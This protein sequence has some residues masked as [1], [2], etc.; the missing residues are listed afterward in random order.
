MLMH[1]LFFIFDQKYYKQCDSVAKLSFGAPLVNVF[2]CHFENIWLE[3]FL[4]QFKPVVYWR[5]VDHT[6]LFF[7]STEHVENFK[8]YLNN[9]HKSISFA[10][11]MEQ[12]GSM[13][14]L[15]LKKTRE[16]NKCA[17][18]VYQ[19]LTFGGFFTNFETF[20]SKYHICSLIDTW[21]YRGFSLSFS[22]EKFHHEVSF[23]KSVLKSNGCPNNFI[24]SSIKH[25]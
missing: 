7:C 22:I 10:S 19:K 8:K 25:F 2:K 3:N 24:D 21:L 9:Q 14:F 12:N 13:S 20:I 15:D 1:K 16:N 5:Y 6:F 23:L 4:T 11:E 18:S 17:D